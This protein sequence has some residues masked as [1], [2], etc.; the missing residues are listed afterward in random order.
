MEYKK[1]VSIILHCSAVET[2]EKNLHWNNTRTHSVWHELRTCWDEVL[3]LQLFTSTSQKTKHQPITNQL[4]NEKRHLYHQYCSLIR[5]A[6]TSVCS[7]PSLSLRLEV[8]SHANTRARAT[9]GRGPE[10]TIRS[11][12]GWKGAGAW[13]YLI[14]CLRLPWR[15]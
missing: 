6:D 5:D 1:Y 10:R 13:L 14:T 15:L 9:D 11:G 12:F 2:Q 8:S 3:L 4:A 7:P